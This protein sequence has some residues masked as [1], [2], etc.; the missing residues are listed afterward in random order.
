MNKKITVIITCA[1][2]CL[3]SL[4]GCGEE[5]CG[6]EACLPV[7]IPGCFDSE[8]CCDDCGCFLWADDEYIECED[9]DCELGIASAIIY[10]GG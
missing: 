8:V 2:V 9:S 5:E 10:C 4:A 6:D 7:T 3:L 1:T